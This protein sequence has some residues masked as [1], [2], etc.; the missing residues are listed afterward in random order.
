VLD[1]LSV[2]HLLALLLVGVFVFGPDKLPRAVA[3]AARML[4]T[5]RQLARDATGDLSRQL[6]TEVTVEDLDPRTF[7]RRHLLSDDDQRAL[8]SPLTDL[9]DELNTT[10]PEKQV[11]ARFDVDT[12]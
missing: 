7:V 5:V 1:N 10:R 11:R 9:A 12:T 3:D 6:G 4:R 2:W 8:L